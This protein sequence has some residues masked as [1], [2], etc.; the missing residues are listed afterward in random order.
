MMKTIFKVLVSFVF[1]AVAASC[2]HDLSDLVS[3][4]G[5]DTSSDGKVT[6][7]LN[8]K[9]L[10]TRAGG[11]DTKKDLQRPF[12]K[13]KHLRIVIVNTDFRVMGD[14]MDE[15]G[16]YLPAA[17]PPRTNTPWNVEVNYRI[18]EDMALGDVLDVAGKQLKFPNIEADR[19]KRI[20]IFINCENIDFTVPLPD[21]GTTTCQ[22][23]DGNALETL[24]GAGKIHEAAFDPK[25]EH[26][27]Q[28]GRLPIDDC[29]YSFKDAEGLPYV[30]VYEVDVPRAEQLKD[31]VSDASFVE[32]L[33]EVGPLYLVRA[34]NRIRFVYINDTAHADGDEQEETPID[35]IDIEVVGWT[36]S[37][38]ADRAYLMPQLAKRTPD[39]S[40]GW[41]KN[42]WALGWKNSKPAELSVPPGYYKKKDNQEVEGGEY[43]KADDYYGGAWVLWLRQEAEKTQ[44]TE[45]Y[46]GPD[47]EW[48]TRYSVPEGVEH[49]PLK[50]PYDPAQQV[51]AGETV[52]V[53]GADDD[54]DA[55]YF[56]E[57]KYS[58]DDDGAQKEYRLTV[59]VRNGKDAEAKDYS[60][61]LPNSLSL[62]RNTDL[63]VRVRFSKLRTD[64]LQMEVDV[65]PYG[66]YEL[67]PV[68][69]LDR[70]R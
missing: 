60:A 57:S 70:T 54:K 13:P 15:D 5:Q 31:Y 12:E 56:A 46:N 58:P 50:H 66:V 21:G 23:T 7:L 53:P 6:L 47:Y 42:G 26:P 59:T 40:G 8:V 61:V 3:E 29:T 18:S 43:I 9:T 35:P 45:D 25:E 27:Y 51:L 64:G 1:A 65:V 52:W 16:N 55:V 69:G 63:L 49:N 11:T 67:E 20:Y 2:S 34:A 17:V 48:L 14:E 37:S 32:P 38:T 68:F 19:K 39:A 24:F 33:F 4:G 44:Q 36:L 30:G 62:F 22:L 41:Q 10:Q 28:T